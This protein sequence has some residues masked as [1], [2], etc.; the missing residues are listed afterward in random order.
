MICIKKI[1]LISS[2]LIIVSCSDRI[3]KETVAKS[4]AIEKD[5]ARVLS[6]H[7]AG[8]LRFR[9]SYS[10]RMF[11]E[12]SDKEAD[13][14][15]KSN[16]RVYETSDSTLLKKIAEFGLVTRNYELI[17]NKFKFTKKSDFNLT[18]NDVE[19]VSCKIVRPANADT[20]DLY[21]LIATSGSY[22]SEVE[23]EGHYGVLNEDIKFLIYDVIQGG[24]Q[25][26]LVLH[27]YYIMN[28]DNSD[29]FIYEVKWN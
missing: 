9:R 14:I 5:K 20:V 12:M 11:R 1:L 16:P 6:I 3:A 23:I 17:R 29:V 26:L 18:G 24:Y 21:N 22:R 15:E 10:D 13:S 28:G 8:E 25:E 4:N 2:L 27:E 19:D 7:K